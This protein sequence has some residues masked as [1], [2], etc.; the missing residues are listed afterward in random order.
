MKLT[1]R[2]GATTRWHSLTKDELDLEVLV[3]AHR[4][5]RLILYEVMGAEPGTFQGQAFVAPGTEGLVTKSGLWMPGAH[6]AASYRDQDA[7]MDDVDS[8]DFCVLL[9][10]FCMHAHCKAKSSKDTV[11][12]I[13]QSGG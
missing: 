2:Q 5:K 3:L 7:Y 10:H 9:Y 1:E 8:G 13:S 6:I 11:G 4:T 12:R